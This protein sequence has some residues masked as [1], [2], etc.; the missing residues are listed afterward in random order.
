MSAQA[1]FFEAKIRPLLAQRCFDCHGRETQESGLRL[2]SLAAMLEGGDSGPAIVRGSS[3]ESLLVEAIN[4]ASLQM[5]P[6]EK[7]IEVDLPN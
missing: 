6:D 3:K 2:D 1:R 5:P 7:L 4:Y